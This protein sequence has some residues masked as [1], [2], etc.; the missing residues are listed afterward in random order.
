MY[1]EL[2]TNNLG[3]IPEVEIVIGLPPLV[4]SSVLLTCPLIEWTTEVI[5][6]QLDPDYKCRMS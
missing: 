6:S 3:S 4:R 5:V 1:P 2:D